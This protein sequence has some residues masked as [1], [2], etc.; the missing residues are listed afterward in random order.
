MLRYGNTR[1]NVLG[2]EV[3]LPD[4]SVWDGL[5]ALRKNNTGYDLKQLFIGSEGMLV[6][7][8]TRHDL[9]PQDKFTGFKPPEPTIPNSPG[10]HAEWIQACKT[11]SAT[12]S[13][14]GYAG[15]L[16]EMVL[17]G[18]VASRAGKKIEWDSKAMKVTNCPEAE[19]FIRLTYR[20]GWSLS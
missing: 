3:V 6:S 4:G 19:P 15:P 17:L 12:G 8:Y 18:N 13:H 14:F 1:D 11:G 16:T 5:Y 10:H 7:N 2:L 20:D 9:L